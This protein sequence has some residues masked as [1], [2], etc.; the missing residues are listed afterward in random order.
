MAFSKELNEFYLK[1]MY[2]KDNQIKFNSN[3]NIFIKPAKT[4]PEFS[5]MDKRNNYI[6]SNMVNLSPEDFRYL[7][8]Y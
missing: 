7:L 8:E 1:Q 3:K 4:K 2:K 6:Y 5:C